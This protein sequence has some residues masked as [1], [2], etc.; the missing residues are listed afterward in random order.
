[1]PNQKQRLTAAGTK[2]GLA[3]FL[4]IYSIM[5]GYEVPGEEMEVGQTKE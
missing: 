2:M 1:M 4:D 3:K 5:G